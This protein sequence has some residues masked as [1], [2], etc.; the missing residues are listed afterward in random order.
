MRYSTLRNLVRGSFS[1]SYG[2]SQQ[3]ILGVG[4]KKNQNAFFGKTLQSERFCSFFLFEKQQLKIMF[5]HFQ[6]Y[7]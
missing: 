6:L 1:L 3:I 5:G 2:N 7:F 4:R